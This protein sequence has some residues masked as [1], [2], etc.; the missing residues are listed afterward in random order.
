M[1]AGAWEEERMENYC[2]MDREL[3]FH[4]MKRVTEMDGDGG[5]ATYNL[6]E[7]CTEE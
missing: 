1:V 2:L 6:T 3:Q 4:K 5:C 7:V